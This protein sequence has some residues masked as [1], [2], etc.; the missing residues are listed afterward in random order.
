MRTAL[1]S[2]LLAHGSLHYAGELRDSICD[3]YSAHRSSVSTRTKSHYNE[4]STGLQNKACASF[5]ALLSRSS[6][7]IEEALFSSSGPVYGYQSG[8]S[9]VLDVF[10]VLR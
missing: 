6:T 4:T 2:A 3:V 8:G 1:Q 9:R 10:Q 5:N 7:K